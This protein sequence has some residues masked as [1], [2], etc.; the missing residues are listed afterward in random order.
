MT[1]KDELWAIFRTQA[2]H[3][4]LADQIERKLQNQ[5]KQSFNMFSDNLTIADSESEFDL[6]YSDDYTLLTS[7]SDPHA[8]AATSM[9]DNYDRLIKMIGVHPPLE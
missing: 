9:H 7:A 1:I 6:F 8:P 5:N 3:Q 4:L 2:S